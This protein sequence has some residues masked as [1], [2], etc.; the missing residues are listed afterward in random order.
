[1][2]FVII[3]KNYRTSDFIE[4]SSFD[5][6]LHKIKQSDRKKCGTALRNEILSV[7]VNDYIEVRKSMT[8]AKYCDKTQCAAV[9]SS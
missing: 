3:Q 5:A 1:M 8:S 6:F 9:T 2:I 4:I 7:K